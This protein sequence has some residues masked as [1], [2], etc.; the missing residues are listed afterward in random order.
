MRKIV[1]TYFYED[2]EEK[3]ATYGN[4]FLDLAERN[5]IYWQTIYSF[6]FSLIVNNS[7]IDYLF[8]TNKEEFPFKKKLKSMGVEVISN[9]ELTHRNKSKWATVKFF[10]DVVSYVS[11]SKRISN[12]DLVLLLDTDV[13]C[14]NSL[15]SIFNVMTKNK[16]PYILK[17][18]NISETESFHSKPLHKLESIYFQH[19]RNLIKIKEFIG[20]EFFGFKKGDIKLYLEEF[21]SLSSNPELSTEEQILTMSHSFN[22]F[23]NINEN[24]NAIY[25][26][27][28]SIRHVDIP[29]SWRNY[30]FLHLP[31]EK[32]IGISRIYKNIASKNPEEINKQDFMRLFNQCI[33]L[34]NRLLLFFRN[35][36]SKFK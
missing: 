29:K 18:T 1:A 35:F 25:R 4:I 24:I 26:V 8:F 17:L 28:T 36:F 12:D 10:F 19:F 30:N 31:S 16:G 11:K 21:E 23:N 15:D 6:Y 27:W 13:I 7:E 3:G 33:P 2:T 5:K 22:N 9:I 34:N 32:S 14:L 20:G